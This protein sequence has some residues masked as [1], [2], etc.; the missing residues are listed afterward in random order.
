MVLIDIDDVHFHI[1]KS[2]VF[3]DLYYDEEEEEPMDIP[4]EYLVDTFIPISNENSIK[5]LE[6]LSY[7]DIDFP[8]E[9]Y[10]YFYPNRFEIIQMLVN[11]KLYHLLELVAINLYIRDT[12]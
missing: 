9:F 12:N 6:C 4:E 2:I 8:D 5:I 7:W 3:K 1:R 11:K 10:E